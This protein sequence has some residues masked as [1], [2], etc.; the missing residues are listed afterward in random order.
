MLPLERIF[1]SKGLDACTDVT[2]FH[3]NALE[4]EI[5]VKRIT[6]QNKGLTLV[7]MIL[8]IALISIITVSFL[9]L[10]VMSSQ[11]NRKSEMALDS[12][13]LGK[14]AM[15]LVYQLSKSEEYKELEDELENKGYIKDAAS[16]TFEYEY[17]DKRLL[18]MGFSEEGALVRVV[19]K[20]F[21]DDTMNELEAQYESLYSWKGRGILSEK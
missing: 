16:G 8:A 17:P 12:T 7:E 1:L 2:N 4:G 13:Y 10:F 18:T 11:I 3:A 5:K 6:N 19:I 9:T 21:K 14:D 15:E 20:I